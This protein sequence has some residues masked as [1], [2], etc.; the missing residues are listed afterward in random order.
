MNYLPPLI[1]FLTVLIDAGVN[2]YLIQV[3]DRKIKH[4]IELSWYT[5]I[6]LL[7]SVPFYFY[8]HVKIGWLAAF[9]MA[10]RLTFFDPFLNIFRGKKLDYEGDPNKPDSEKSIYDRIELL[11]GISINVF[12]VLYLA[13][14]ILILI[15]FIYAN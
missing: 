5:L 11:T 7:I 4:W 6:C 9:A 10:S 15:I 3:K 14:Y 1:Y 12:R 2:A 13:S 8:F